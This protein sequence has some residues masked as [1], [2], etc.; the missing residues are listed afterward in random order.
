MR[1][2]ALSEGDTPPSDADIELVSKALLALADDNQDATMSKDEF[3]D[4]ALHRSPEAKSYLAYFNDPVVDAELLVAAGAVDAAGI[5][6]LDVED[7]DEDPLGA[8]LGEEKPKVQR[9]AMA[10]MY[11]IDLEAAA[12]KEAAAADAGGSGGHTFGDRSG[13]PVEIIQPGPSG[14]G[15]S[16]G[17]DFASA[18]DEVL[19][20]ADVMADEPLLMYEV[21]P[22]EVP[23]N[24]EVEGAQEDL[25]GP[26]VGLDLEYIHGYRCHDGAR[27][28]VRVTADGML[29]YPAA[30]VGVALDPAT[31]SQRFM[32]DHAD[33]VVGLALAPDGR[34]VAS[35]EMG[36]HA[37]V[38][39]WRVAGSG[40]AAGEGKAYD[41]DA[42]DLLPEVVLAAKSKRGLSHVAFSPDGTRI[43]AVGEDDE[44]TVT[45]WE[46][47][48]RRRI[49]STTTT[50]RKVLS[51]TWKDDDTVV[52]AGM[53]H[54]FFTSVKEQTPRKALFG[55]LRGVK[56]Q[57]LVAVATLPTLTG[58][59]AKAWASAGGRS[60]SRAS[61]SRTKQGEVVIT[62]TKSGDLYIWHG[63]SCAAFKSGAHKG[64]V[65]SLF[66][67]YDDNV[68]NAPDLALASGGADGVVKL[69]S[70]HGDIVAKVDFSSPAWGCLD[71]SVR[72]VCW[73]G[74]GGSAGQ[75]LVVAVR[76]GE[77]YSL[78]LADVLAGGPGGAGEGK[79]DDLT[80]FGAAA[81]PLVSGHSN[82]ETWGLAPHPS[83]ADMFATSGD[84]AT[85]RIW[86]FNTQIAK[87]A[88]P[89]LAR[90]VA[91]SPDGSHVAVGLGGDFGG[92][93]RDGKG[94]GAWSGR[95]G[96]GVDADAYA[97]F[98]PS[99]LR[100][101]GFIVF[102]VSAGGRAL[103]PVHAARDQVEWVSD[104]KFSP[105]GKYL[106][107]GSHDNSVMVYEADGW[108][109][110]GKCNKSSSFITRLDWAAD[111]SVIRTNDGA[112]EI[113][114]FFPDGSQALPGHSFP[115]ETIDMVWATNTCPHNEAA[116]GIWPLGA[117]GTDINATAVSSS[118]DVIVVGDD[119]SR[120]N[121][122]PFPCP[123]DGTKPL[124]Y[125]GHASFVQNVTFLA[126]DARVVTVGGYDKTVAVWRVVGGDVDDAA[127]E[128]GEPEAEPVHDPDEVGAVAL[129]RPSPL[130]EAIKSG[131]IH[132]A[133]RLREQQAEQNA[134]FGTT[135]SSAG[136]AAAPAS[137]QLAQL[138]PGSAPNKR[139]WM[140]TPEEVLPRPAWPHPITA[141]APEQ[142]LALSYVHGY[143]GHDLRN[144]LGYTRAGAV[145]YPAAALGV[146]TAPVGSEAH[147]GSSK[148]PSQQ[149]FGGHT[150][151][152]LT[153]AVHPDGVHIATG[154]I[155]KDPIIHVWNAEAMEPVASLRGVVKRAVA[156]LSFSPDG[157]RLAAVGRDEYNSVSVYDWKNEVL[158]ASAAGAKEP[159]LAMAFGMAA[160]AGKGGSDGLCIVQAG[161]RHALF[162]SWQGRSVST[163]KGLLGV[164]AKAKNFY[165]AAWVGGQAVL[166]TDTGA[167]Y[168]FSGRQ[169]KRS[170]KSHKGPV[171]AL[172]TPTARATSGGVALFSGG[173]DGKVITYSADLSVLNTFDVAEAAGSL[174]V[175]PKIRALG[176]SDDG[177][178]LAVGTISC[179]IVELSTENG[180]IISTDSKGNATA[181]VR[182]HYR[183]ELWGLATSPVNP[184]TYVTV[185]DDGMLAVWSLAQRTCVA[186]SMLGGVAR[187]VA[188]HPTG[189]LLAVGLGGDSNRTG[190]SADDTKSKGLDGA[191]MVL[192]TATLEV[193]WQ[194]K[195]A[196][197]WISDIKFSPDGESLAV[198]SHDNSVYVYDVEEEGDGVR[199]GLRCKFSKHSSFVK[200]LDF[201]SDSAYMQVSAG[202]HELLFANAT[203]GE[204]VVT[205]D[206]LDGKEWATN[207]TDLAWAL[208]GV[209]PRGT[210][211]TDVNAVDVTPTPLLRDAGP[212]DAT[213]V[214]GDDFGR[215]VQ[216]RYPCVL[217]KAGHKSYTGH[218]SHVT[219]VAFAS[220]GQWVVSTGGFD[221]CTFVWQ[222]LGD[223][224]A[225]AEVAEAAAAA[226]TGAG[227]ATEL[228]KLAGYEGRGD[229]AASVASDPAETVAGSTARDVDFAADRR[230][231]ANLGKKALVP[232]I[233]SHSDGAAPDAGLKLEWVYG[234]EGV[235][236]R[237]NLAYNAAG[238]IVYYAAGTGIVY[239][240]TE[241]AQHFYTKH[242]DDIS[243]LAMDA[244]GAFVA[245]GEMGRRPSVR[246][247]RAVGAD[248]VITLPPVHMRAVISLSF[249][250]SGHFLMSV[251]DDDMHTVA[252]YYSAAGDWHDAV[253]VGKEQSDTNMVLFSRCLP[254]ADGRSPGAYHAVTGGK[255]HLKFWQFPVTATGA[256]GSTRTTTTALSSGRSRSHGL[257][258]KKGL[259][260]E[261]L[262]SIATDAV[263]V[264]SGSSWAL[265]VGTTDGSLLNYGQDRRYSSSAKVGAGVTAMWGFEGG[266]VVGTAAGGVHVFD[267][268]LAKTSSYN[269]PGSSGFGALVRSVAL[270]PDGRSLLVGTA[271][272]EVWE[273]TRDTANASRLVKGHYGRGEVWGL[274]VA[275]G[276]GQADSGNP[277]LAATSGDDGDIIVWDLQRRVA[278]SVTNVSDPAAHGAPVRTLSWTGAWGNKAG[279]GGAR[280]PYGLIAAGIGGRLGGTRADATNSG[281]VCLFDPA[282]G[283]VLSGLKVTDADIN[284]LLISPDGTR[285][286]M[287]CADTKVYIAAVAGESG[288]VPSFEVQQ[289][290]NKNTS[291]VR[292]VS[293]DASS[294]T[295]MADDAGGE[296]LYFAADSG[297]QV[298]ATDAELTDRGIVFASMNCVFGEKVAGIWP[299]YS[300]NTDV[301]ATDTSP[302]GKLLATADDYGDVRLF[303][304]PSTHRRSA[305]V[306]GVGAH[307]SHVTNVRFTRDGSH[308]LTTGG[309][310]R[311]LM[312]W[313]VTGGADSSGAS[314]T[315][316]K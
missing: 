201:T 231:R 225:A 169:R 109:T 262:G 256:A 190:D 88:L 95:G 273:V 97:G 265:I 74:Q 171:Y 42:N 283:K 208:L 282:A 63:R 279:V 3:L 257:S 284:S 229:D 59:E 46:W 11:G 81:V 25:V 8:A 285:M 223:A 139:P 54:A 161:K 83:E 218:S 117:D 28:H 115:G 140:R 22:D 316:H 204:H 228:P 191:V 30:A 168:V 173:A 303:K 108:A 199:V 98:A 94:R 60:H 124:R 151:D 254:P 75:Q 52:T 128:G 129:R 120:V 180:S 248:H 170:V 138:P 39:V 312:Q 49:L 14:P 252:V 300:D 147:D 125:K 230:S 90:C 157:S 23:S 211:G 241:H 176:L 41:T 5:S 100:P 1:G 45:V 153:V 72:S 122:H 215:V 236:G 50:N 289:V 222:V 33:D 131:D 38:V 107:V 160:G 267:L 189:R 237:R 4:F 43:A 159:T 294:T 214:A 206:T 144:N 234:Y 65:T 162:H 288:A 158:V 269:A 278:V 245:T 306:A 106:A 314:S 154:Q 186:K 178:K 275:P 272:C 194:E 277:F 304:Y 10:S 209:H 297:E 121:L 183:D 53:N 221:R 249:D 148:S 247:W 152:V 232:T 259:M 181:L 6:V 268:G 235:R 281:E 104:L 9:K 26:P 276:S 198:G 184:D 156:G 251:G 76:S 203:T 137:A 57:P 280:A 302:D 166:G 86:R 290:C 68:P 27:N 271:L 239:N 34:T 255:K 70:K 44:H 84:D 210:D 37:R 16:G 132:K 62:G 61:T 226:A 134:L 48:R 305:S 56:V 195:R 12:A 133:A 207:T 51:L 20:Q 172:H 36:K 135:E 202:S 315:S 292:H 291:V 196:K 142:D 111:S 188:F 17:F 143:R 146:V 66:A 103:T 240:R 212:A 31:R 309:N 29:V 311:T 299:A 85:L 193:L 298:L 67:P 242:A 13:A 71:A 266:L 264:G 77:I 274:A 15:G 293:W 19:L 246:V 175:R 119:F 263:I 192:S 18:G 217:K 238:G 105:D 123:P 126:D 155:G 260:G 112:H 73:G 149:F 182:G 185:G 224:E 261:H 110:A 165:A 136:A 250:P 102:A 296:A 96:E 150:D 141:A 177:S 213:V 244:S 220:D 82:F 92:I 7:D 78:P 307:S 93:L 187:A 2:M 286:A 47:Q 313:R 164:R 55:R 167:L 145:V 35:I 58:G 127:T 80:G 216:Y 114:Y 233:A 40:A 64:A 174:L 200:H 32:A 295:V 270:R 69:W 116:L 89:T 227:S 21:A 243:A 118:G 99:D 219:K 113:L 308:V 79:G 310:D 101:G 258:T 205:K 163:R 24:A 179:E 197:E 91:W 253:L 301:N 130:E 287:G 87:R